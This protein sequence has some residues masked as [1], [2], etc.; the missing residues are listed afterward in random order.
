MIVDAFEH[1]SIHFFNN[2][3]VYKN[4][5]VVYSLY[6]HFSRYQPH[7]TDVSIDVTALNALQYIYSKILIAL[8]TLM[9]TNEFFPSQFTKNNFNGHRKSR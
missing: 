7:G 8:M 1:L 6:K 4:V 5:S 9:L 2:F 3:V